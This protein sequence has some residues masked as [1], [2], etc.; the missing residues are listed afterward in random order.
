MAHESS[1]LV[2]VHVFILLLHFGTYKVSSEP[3]VP[4]YFIFGDSLVDNGNNNELYSKWKANYRPYGIDFPKVDTGRFCNGRTTA[5]VIGIS[6]CF[7]LSLIL[8][9]NLHL[10]PTNKKWTFHIYKNNQDKYL[11]CALLLLYKDEI[12]SKKLKIDEHNNH[13]I[14]N[15]P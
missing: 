10:Q 8:F 11:F 12:Y 1:F 9:D 2:L 14:L 7:F 15:K 5:D 4:C 3:K 6:L 13:F